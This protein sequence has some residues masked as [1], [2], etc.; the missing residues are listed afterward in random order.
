MNTL[1]GPTSTKI[2]GYKRQSQTVSYFFAPKKRDEGPGTMTHLGHGLDNGIDDLI[3]YGAEQHRPIAHMEE[4]FT[5]RRQ[6]ETV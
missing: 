5:S 2:P 1:R 3:L 4:H 6:H